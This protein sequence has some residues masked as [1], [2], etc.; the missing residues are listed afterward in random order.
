MRPPT[1]TA[2]IRAWGDPAAP[3]G[4]LATVVLAA[5]VLALSCSISPAQRG[6]AAEPTPSCELADGEDRTVARIIDGETLALDGGSEVRLVGALAPRA[7]DAAGETATWPLADHARVALQEIV[8]SRNVRLAF[9]GR[10]TDRYGRLLAHVFARSGETQVWVQGEM[11]KRG[12]ARA[13]GLEGSVA[14]LAELIAHEAVAREQA[15]GLWAETAYAVRGADDVSALLRLTGT[16]QVVEGKV[17]DVSDIRGATYVNFGQDWRQDFTAVLR[18][19][20]RRLSASGPWRADELKGRKIRVRGWIERRGGPMID[21]AH[22]AAIEVLAAEADTEAA[23]APPSSRRR[24]RR[25]AA[26]P[27]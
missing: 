2:G 16:F 17:V 3:G 13:Y 27:E 25:P 7:F 4:R 20:A 19:P 14:C 5:L 18:A 9:S 24:I 8:A 26:R 10:R 1:R 15:A 21:V 12:L 11:L 6:K 22:P 23:P